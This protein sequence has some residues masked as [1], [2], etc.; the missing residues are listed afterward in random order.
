MYVACPGQSLLQ[1]GKH[2]AVKW[3]YVCEKAI[4]RNCVVDWTVLKGNS[5]VR[6]IARYYVSVAGNP[7]TLDTSIASSRRQFTVAYRVSR[8]MARKPH[9]IP[10]RA[11]TMH[12]KWLTLFAI[13]KLFRQSHISLKTILLATRNVLKRASSAAHCTSFNSVTFNDVTYVTDD[14]DRW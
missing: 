8:T 3:N 7:D 11:G 10:V 9:R 12:R 2:Q 4:K 6:L 13:Q 1:R 5:I 14:S